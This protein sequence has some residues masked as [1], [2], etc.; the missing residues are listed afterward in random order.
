[1]GRRGE[2]SKNF[3]GGMENSHTAMGTKEMNVLYFNPEKKRRTE[4]MIPAG[5]T[6]RYLPRKNGHIESPARRGCGKKNG[7]VTRCGKRK[8]KK[9]FQGRGW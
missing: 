4:Y 9:E 7:I 8:R 6:N 1:M 3:L 2:N 5:E